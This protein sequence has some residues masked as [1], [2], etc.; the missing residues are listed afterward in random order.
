MINPGDR[1]IPNGTARWIRKGSQPLPKLPELSRFR[2]K[3]EISLS[4]L[5]G[6]LFLDLTSLSRVIE[7]SPDGQR[8][9][10]MSSGGRKSVFYLE[11]LNLY[12]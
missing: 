8:V 4:N 11:D 2:D 12:A 6:A 10:V 9:K 7:V 5:E 1:V 3:D